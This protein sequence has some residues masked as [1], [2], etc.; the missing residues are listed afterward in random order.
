VEVDSTLNSGS[1]VHPPDSEADQGKILITG[2]A[3]RIANS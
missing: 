1:L 2:W 3:V